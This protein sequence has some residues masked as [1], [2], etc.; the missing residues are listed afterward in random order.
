[1]GFRHEDLTSN[2]YEEL[3][4]EYEFIDEYLN[5]DSEL[6]SMSIQDF[7][8]DCRVRDYGSTTEDLLCG[9]EDE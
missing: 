2:E 4:D 9:D 7:D 3:Y 1:M 5:R 6:E 8:L